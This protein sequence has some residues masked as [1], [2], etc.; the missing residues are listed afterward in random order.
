MTLRPDKRRGNDVDEAVQLDAKAPVGVKAVIATL[1]VTGVIGLAA[2][3][4][5]GLAVGITYGVRKMAQCACEI[6]AERKAVEVARVPV[7]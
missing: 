1:I 4:V 3:A 5:F 2:G 6:E 7:S